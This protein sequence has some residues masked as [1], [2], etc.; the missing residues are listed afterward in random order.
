MFTMCFDINFVPTKPFNFN[1][2]HK[3]PNFLEWTREKKNLAFF[4]TQA[5]HTEV[6]VHKRTYLY[7]SMQSFQQCY[8]RKT[9]SFYFT[10]INLMQMC[11]LT[12]AV[13]KLPNLQNAFK[14]LFLFERYTDFQPVVLPRKIQVHLKNVNISFFFSG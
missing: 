5:S 14:D 10:K 12:V 8:H 13:S 3:W 7:I 11:N 9:L 6:C 2:C 4:L 1:S